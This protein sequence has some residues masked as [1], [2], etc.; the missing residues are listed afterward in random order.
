MRSKFFKCFFAMKDAK[1][2]TQ[3]GVPAEVGQHSKTKILTVF[4]IERIS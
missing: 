3:Y 1:M 2:D 4:F